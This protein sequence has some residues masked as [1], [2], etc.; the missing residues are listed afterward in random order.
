MRRRFLYIFVVAICFFAQAHAKMWSILICTLE[1]RKESFAHIY[2]KLQQ[3]IQ[4][5]GLQDDVEVCYFLDNREHSVG[6]KRNH[7]LQHCCGKYV[8]YVDDDDDVHDAY[9]PMIYEKLCKDP[10]CVYLLGV[11]T[12]DGQDPHYF[13]HSI[14]YPFWFEARDVYYRPP[15]HLNPI[16]RDIAVQ[17]LFPEINRGEDADWSMQIARSG[18]LKKEEYVGE[19]YYFYNSRR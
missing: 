11:I 18:L 17:F 5:A 16:R 4:K 12:F 9:V 19:A 15:N 10:D 1:E 13:I 3:Q 7:L 6:F 2:N 8:C 14:K